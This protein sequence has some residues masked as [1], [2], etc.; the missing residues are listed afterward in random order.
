MIQQKCKEK[1]EET[2]G[3]LRNWM[4]NEGN[5]L[6]RAEYGVIEANS[7]PRLLN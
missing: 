3:K 7:T 5:D 1:D 4:K 2:K 6:V